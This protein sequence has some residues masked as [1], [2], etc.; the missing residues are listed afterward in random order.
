MPMQSTADGQEL[1]FEGQPFSAGLSPGANQYLARRSGSGW[2]AASITPPLAINEGEKNG[3]KAVSEDLTRGVLY[4]AGP[5]LAGG[6][7]PGEGGKSFNE[8][9]L[10]EAGASSL[11]PLVTARPPHRAPGPP[12]N[13]LEPNAFEIAFAGANAGAGQAPAF[14]HLVFEANDAL[15]AAVPGIAPGAPEVGEGQ[16]RASLSTPNF[17]ESDCNLYEWVGG[18]LRLVSVLPGD[19]AAATGAVLGSGR[20]LA[21]TESS[22]SEPE[23][24]AAAV[25]HAISADGSRIFWS[26]QSGQLFVRIDGTE[27]VEVKDPGQFLVATPDGSKVLLSDGCLYD[28][29]AEACESQLTK[30]PAGFLGVLGASEDLSRIYFASSEALLPGSSQ[31]EAC[32]GREEEE[33]KWP[34][35]RAATCTSTTKVK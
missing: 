30:S 6:V 33:G 14:S 27:T 26:D 2:S 22:N 10:W 7:P 17:P 21:K 4:Q 23:L 18:Q 24:E 11:T 20:R 19:G 31:P 5:A 28:V 15:T 13:S 29:A 16:C 25:D 35:G 9:Y 3:F 34:P 12:G 1:L 8:L 32:K